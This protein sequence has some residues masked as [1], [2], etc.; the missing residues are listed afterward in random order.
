[1]NPNM[2]N[3]RFSLLAIFFTFSFVPDVLQAQNK[4]T[5]LVSIT[6]FRLDPGTF[7]WR[8][9]NTYYDMT[10]WDSSPYTEGN[11]K[12]LS[13][14][15]WLFRMNYRLLF[16][17]G[18][19]ASYSK[20]F[21]LL[22]M[23]HGAGER[24]NCWDDN[25]YCAGCNPN[26]TPTTARPEFL[27]NDHTLTQGG[28][29]L[30]SAVQLAGTK[31]LGDPTLDPRAFPGLVV[32]PQNESGWG[33]DNASNTAVSYM[34]RLIRLLCKKYNID[35]N[36]IYIHGLSLGGQAV[37]KAMNMADWMFAAGLT[38]SALPYS[39]FIEYDSVTNIPFWVFQGGRDSDPSPSETEELVRE[40]REAGGTIQ[41]TLYPAL[42]HRTW[43]QAYREKDFY[44]WF[45]TKSKSD[46]HVYYD[47]PNICIS[48]GQ[49][50]KLGLAQGFPAYEWEK[51][52]QIIPDA[53]DYI[54]TATQPGVYRARF[55]RI[56]SNPQE[57]QWNEWSK[58]VTINNTPS[59][60][61]V[62][63]QRGTT[64]L[65]D[66]N[67]STNTILTA[68]KGY[69]H[70]YWFKDGEP[71]NLAD[72]STVVLTPGQCGSPCANGGQYTLKVAGF[73]N[74]PSDASAAKPV[75]FENQ[76]P[77]DSRVSP[78]VFSAQI[79]SPSSVFLSWAE[80]SQSELGF[81]VWRKNT[82]INSPWQLATLTAPN[83]TYYKDTLLMPGSTY[84][85]KIRGLG[86]NGRSDYLP[87]NDKDAEDQNLVV[88]LPSTSVQPAPPQNLS[89]KVTDLNAI[90]LTWKAGR[91]DTEI[92]KYL[93]TYNGSAIE[94]SD[95]TTT[96]VLGNLTVNTT[97]AITVK[98]VDASGVQSPPSNQ[99]SANTYSTGLFYKYA[100][101]SW[102]TLDD[103]S[104]I[105]T[106]SSPEL[107]GTVSN[108]T[109]QPRTQDDYFNFQFEGYLHISNAG[110]YT[111]YLNSDEGSRM[112]LDDQLIIDNNGIHNLCTGD[113]SSTSCPNGWGKPSSSLSLS[114]GP[115]RIKV[116]MFE[117]IGTQNLN[118]LY[119]GPDTGNATTAIPNAAL[120]SG[121]Y[122]PPSALV[123]PTGLSASA[124]G[125]TTIQLSWQYASN[126][127]F[128]VY[129]ADKS[130][131]PYQLINTLNNRSFLDS[132]LHP[133]TSYFYRIRAVNN[134]SASGFSAIVSAKTSN[135]TE[136]PSKPGDLKASSIQARQTTLTWSASTDNVGVR[137]Y[138]IWSNGKKTG[139]SAQP[140]YMVTNLDSGKIY[141]FYVVAVDFN[142]NR[143]VP[144]D[145]VT[146][147]FVITGL[148]DLMNETF[149]ME[150]YPNP[151]E[152]QEIRL[153]IHSDK[154]QD[155]ILQLLDPVG[156][157]VISRRLG[158]DQ[159]NPDVILNFP[160]RLPSGM[161][162]L[163]LAQGQR[164][165]R[166]KVIVR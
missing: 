7:S 143:S 29:Q 63:G 109:L 80:A 42:A 157:V 48:T 26:N 81:E 77:I 19:S 79:L 16:P 100:T 70:Y 38:M 23:L 133:G 101:G 113:A 32:F 127:S 94:T 154:K 91:S 68:P 142:N 149:S 116:Q 54:Y 145:S 25:C 97:Y 83:V 11:L 95:T 82:T 153:N 131:G 84:Y 35:Q 47:N 114:A 130:A 150:V 53:H 36:R 9:T 158:Y 52:G 107:T 128:E 71:A 58:P 103:P 99:I 164:Q 62:I 124:K 76:A 30:L 144:S 118:V 61:P 86:Q 15:T 112:Y 2:N 60:A 111:F 85:Y 92:K 73:D 18:Y 123:T 40:F 51:D 74:C 119:R 166:Q 126:A 139:T 37:F 138:E 55:S 159:Y 110:Q 129:R 115:H 151:V 121:S 117:Y 59:F 12:Q 137:Y 93:V 155:V 17:Q 4:D 34:I 120:T 57:S 141:T 135:D 45:L 147:E 10:S 43:D 67:D 162:F 90:T 106:W 64:F 22:I 72:T 105:S 50:V 24:G 134:A 140:G 44:N 56:S 41:Y 49:G 39:K 89:A 66:L 152:D 5:A 96:F 104:L 122:T 163:T 33:S 65:R 160:N 28:R 148:E 13:G 108:F 87:G 98:A 88:N 132:M 165:V 27:N 8:G 125:M 1:M 6:N 136:R 21:P 75:F 3:V 14:S 161:Y 46:I 31:K 20:G 146:N 69:A 102:T 156:R 78:M